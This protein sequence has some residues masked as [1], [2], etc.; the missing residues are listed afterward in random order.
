M[1]EGDYETLAGFV[2]DRLDHIPQP[3]ERFEHDGWHIEV[4]AMERLRVATVRLVAP[5][6]DD[7]AEINGVVT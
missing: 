7:A 3:G 5:R 6:E 4:V 2:L 1:P